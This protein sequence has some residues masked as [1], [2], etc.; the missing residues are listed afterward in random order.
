MKSWIVFIIFISLVNKFCV[1]EYYQEKIL[2]N[3]GSIKVII[4]RDISK[5]QYIYPKSCGFGWIR[6]QWSYPGYI[7]M[8]DVIWSIKFVRVIVTKEQERQLRVLL[9]LL[10]ETFLRC[11]LNFGA[12]IYNGF[13]DM[14]TMKS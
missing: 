13:I 5:W 14:E 8:R 10:G 2:L 1:L 4:N 7:E 9:L 12:K 6:P 3:Y 11:Y